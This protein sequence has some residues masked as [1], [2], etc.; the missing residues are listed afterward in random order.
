MVAG[1]VGV[2]LDSTYALASYLATHNALRRERERRDELKRL[3]L[4]GLPPFRALIPRHPDKCACC[5]SRE[6]KSHHEQQVCAYCR[7][8][9]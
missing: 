8:V 6:F 5:G 1:V 7:S 3:R 2:I 9:A 4:L